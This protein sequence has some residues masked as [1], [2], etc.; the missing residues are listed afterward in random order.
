MGREGEA[1]GKGKRVG[2]GSEWEG[3]PNGKG[4][5]MGREPTYTFHKNLLSDIKLLGKNTQLIAEPSIVVGIVLER[6]LQLLFSHHG[7]VSINNKCH[8]LSAFCRV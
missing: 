5:R 1:N 3:E 8:T 7:C 2:R 4:K 6:V